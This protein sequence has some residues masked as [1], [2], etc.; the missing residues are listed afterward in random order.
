VTLRARWV[1]LRARWVTLRARWVT[2]RARWVTL[3]AHVVC[4]AGARRA[5]LQPEE[6]LREVAAVCMHAFRHVR[7][8]VQRRLPTRTVT[9]LPPAPPTRRCPLR[10]A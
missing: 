8:E 6:R 4:I 2:L 9:T 1:T 5:G 7:R 10:R 3:R